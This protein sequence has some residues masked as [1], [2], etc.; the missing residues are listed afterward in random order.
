MVAQRSLGLPSLVPDPR[1]HVIIHM[2]NASICIIC[3]LRGPLTM[4]RPFN[5]AVSRSPFAVSRIVSRSAHR[6]F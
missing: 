4:L 3:H 2:A 1:C 6:D 5:S